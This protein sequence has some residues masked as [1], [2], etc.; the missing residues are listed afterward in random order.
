MKKIYLIDFD[1]TITKQDTLDYIAN[2]FHPKEYKEWSKKIKN[3]E[4][5]VKDWLKSFEKAF[6]TE[7]KL[8]IELLKEIE[9]DE[10]FKNFIK[11]KN[12]KIVSGGFIYNIEN[13]LKN[14]EI[15]NIE[16]YGN[17]L[18]FVEN[19]KI[20]INSRYY[21]EKCGKCGVCKTNILNYYKKEYDY[22]VYIGD[23][24]TDICTAR[25]ANKIYA[26][27]GSYLEKKLKEENI[28]F[29]SF[30]KFEEVE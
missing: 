4:F 23:G 14:Y 29:V 5:T 20:K 28:K 9:I 11:G 21:N 30:D 17:D 2:K 26:K 13:V 7:E 25:Y 12:V 6:K 22:I 1:G 27:R 10:T 24:I 18:T 19:N 16:I 3:G 15:D 8:Y